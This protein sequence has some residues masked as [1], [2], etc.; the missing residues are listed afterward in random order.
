[1]NT[2]YAPGAL[3]GQRRSWGFSQREMAELLGFASRGQVSRIER[4]KRTPSIE[5]ALACTALFGVS[6]QE[7]FP[8]LFA[9]IEERFHERVIRFGRGLLHSSTLVAVRKR[10]LLER[11]LIDSYSGGNRSFP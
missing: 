5:T 3:R 10:E 1:M 4:G 8:Q 11:V 6:P 7:L 2:R 9:Q